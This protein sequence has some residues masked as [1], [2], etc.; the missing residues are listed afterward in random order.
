[1]A[2]DG[3]K[4]G[5]KPMLSPQEC[6]KIL[7]VFRF[8]NPKA[9]IR[10]AAGRE[11]HLGHLQALGLYPASSLFMDGYLN[12]KGTNHLQTLEMI[13]DGGFDIVSDQGL[14]DLLA[15]IHAKGVDISHLQTTSS[16]E[17][18]MKTMSDLRPELSSVK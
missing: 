8:L 13:Q 18:V 11:I 9:E 12:T 6:L 2:V 14:E 7:C 5:K 4:L 17:I 1:M 16:S 15:E 10:M 3:N